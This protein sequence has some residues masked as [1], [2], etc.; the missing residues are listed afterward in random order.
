MQL[1]KKQK[2]VSN[3]FALLLIL[4][5]NFEHFENKMTLIGYAF[6][7]LLTSKDFVR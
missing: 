7:K 4:A 3:F 2:I 6:Q 5:S 1:S